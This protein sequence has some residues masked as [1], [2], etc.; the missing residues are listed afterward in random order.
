M[1]YGQCLSAAIV[2]ILHM[3]MV[4]SADSAPSVQ[5]STK[6]VDRD[7]CAL[8]ANNWSTSE[9]HDWTTICLMGEL[10]A[11]GRPLRS[12]FVRELVTKQPFKDRLAGRGLKIFDAVFNDELDLSY[13]TVDPTLELKNDIFHRVVDLSRSTFKGSVVL[14][15]SAFDE[16]LRASGASVS[17]SILLGKTDEN[18]VSPP[19]LFNATESSGLEGGYRGPP[20]RRGSGPGL[21]CWSCLT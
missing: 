2:F 9:K 5:T 14:L 13:L 17:G 15:G 11:G 1:Q 19:R 10:Y 7:E 18:D 4:V 3:G 21:A 16:G 8:F 6:E 12:D 20:E